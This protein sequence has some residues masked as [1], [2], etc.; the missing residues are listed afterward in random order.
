LPKQFDRPVALSTNEAHGPQFTE[1]LA[2]LNKN[3][4]AVETKQFGVIFF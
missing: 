3:G 2:H 1:I 4:I